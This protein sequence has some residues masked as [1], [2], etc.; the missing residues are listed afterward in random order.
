MIRLLRAAYYVAADYGYAAT[1]DSAT[2]ITLL[3]CHAS[4][5]FRHAAMARF[6]DAAAIRCFSLP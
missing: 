4:A 1:L 2:L 5:D 6:A 3:I